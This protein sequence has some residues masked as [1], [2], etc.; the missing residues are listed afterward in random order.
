MG[1]NVKIDSG[2]FLDVLRSLGGSLG[3]QKPYSHP[4]YLLDIHVA[5]TTHVEN[6]A[7]LEPKIT[8]DMRLN[9][10]REGDNPHDEH[11]IRIEDDA[12]NML[13][14]VP[15]GRNEILARLMAAGKQ[16]Y[17]TVQSKKYDGK[18]LKITLRVYLGD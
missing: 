13:G 1:N 11:A 3:G 17:G 8:P 5:G 18:W 10:F 14:Y 12:Q 15:S 7:D 4:I 9:F 2:N 6:I 16:I